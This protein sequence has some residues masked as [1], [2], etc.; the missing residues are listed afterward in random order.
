[1]DPR[2]I[3]LSEEI[4]QDFDAAQAFYLGLLAGLKLNNPATKRN[5]IQH[6]KEKPYLRLVK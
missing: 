3:A 4:I 2:D 5:E 6:N 1:M